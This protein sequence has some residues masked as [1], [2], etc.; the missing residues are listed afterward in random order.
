MQMQIEEYIQQGTLVEVEKE[1]VQNYLQY[2]PVAKKG[3]EK[4]RVTTAFCSVN[5]CTEDPEKLHLQNPSGVKDHI[6]AK[7]WLFHIDLTDAFN[8]I[9][10]KEGA[11][12]YLCI[13]FRGKSYRW[14]GAG[15]GLK[16]DIVK[17]PFVKSVRANVN[18]D[19]PIKVVERKVA[20]IKTTNKTT[21]QQKIINKF[22]KKFIANNNKAPFDIQSLP[23]KGT[24]HPASNKRLYSIR[25]TYEFLKERLENNKN[26]TYVRYGDNDF[27]HIMGV[28]T[29]RPLGNNKTVFTPKLQEELRKSVTINSPD[30]LR[31]YNFGGW[32]VSNKVFRRPVKRMLNVKQYNYVKKVDFNSVYHPVL[33]FYTIAVY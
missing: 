22:K 5:K 2:F 20:A 3:S 17:K 28:N 10:I 32:T 25:H 31:T 7:D 26:F 23:E 12:Y 33:F 6:R 29:R 27:M 14:K 9:S 1:V 21:G 11:T 4:V 13:R 15:F 30:Y 18:T 24:Y 19:K 16:K 8:H